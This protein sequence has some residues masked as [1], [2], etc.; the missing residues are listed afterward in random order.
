MH[1][2]FVDL[3]KPFD[4]DAKDDLVVTGKVKEQMNEA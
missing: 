2:V 1:F 4:R 3:E